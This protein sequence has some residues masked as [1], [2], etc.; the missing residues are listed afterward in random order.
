MAASQKIS[1][2]LQ[3]TCPEVP[4]VKG[5]AG[6]HRVCGAINLRRRVG[7]YRRWRF[8]HAT[9]AGGDVNYSYNQYLTYVSIHATPQV[10]TGLRPSYCER[11]SGPK[12][13]AHVTIFVRKNSTLRSGRPGHCSFIIVLRMARKARGWLGCLRYAQQ[14]DFVVTLRSLRTS[15]SDGGCEGVA[16]NQFDSLWQGSGIRHRHDVVAESPGCLDSFFTGNS[17]RFE[18]DLSLSGAE[19]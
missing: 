9:R 18:E 3:R 11:R 12:L 4:A 1:P 13:S 16:L 17:D 19:L 10:A 6:K 2:T 15:V 14:V 8:I 5:G 7:C